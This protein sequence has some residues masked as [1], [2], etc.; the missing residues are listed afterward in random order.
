MGRKYV[1]TIY[2]Q[3]SG[4][5]VGSYVITILSS[6]SNEANNRGEYNG[7]NILS[8]RYLPQSVETAL[9]TGST[10]FIRQK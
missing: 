8:S 9:F 7:N 3:G 2:C 5:W 4:R 1:I 10:H 6:K